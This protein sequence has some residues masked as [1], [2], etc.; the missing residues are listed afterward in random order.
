M[1]KVISRFILKMWGFRITG[2][3]PEIIPKKIYAVYPHTSNWD[4]PLGLLLRK[5]VPIKVNFIAKDSL[6]K[7]PFGW[8]FRYLGGIPVNRKSSNNFVDTMVTIYKKY[9]RIAFAI[10]PEG[11]RKKVTKFKSGFYYIAVDAKIPIILVTFD[12]GKGECNFSEPF[13]PSGNYVEDMKKIV[14]HFHGAKGRN[15]AD[16]CKFEDEVIYKNI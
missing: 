12:Y 11:T 3:D 8:F 9:D 2:I 14:T 4:F 6:F 1:I 10:A 15:D 16:S 13:Y 5:A 7:P